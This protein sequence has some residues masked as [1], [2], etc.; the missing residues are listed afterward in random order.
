MVATFCIYSQVQ[1]H[2]FTNFDDAIYCCLDVYA[3]GFTSE[4]IKWA[5]TTFA[6]GNWFPVTWFSHI[7]DYQLYGEQA[8]GYLLTNVFFH[9]ANSLLLF[10]VLFRMTGA[11]WQSAFVASMFA[12]HPLNVESV[13]WAA[14]RKNVLSTLFWLLTMW[15][16]VRYSEKSSAKRYGLVFLF[17]TLGL[18]SKSMLVTLPFVL[19]LLDYWPL[20]RFKFRQERGSNDILEKNTAKGPGALGLVLEKVPLFFLTIGL[21]IVTYIAQKRFGNMN[22]TEHLTFFTR[23]TNAMVSYLEYL[24]KV[25]WPEKLAMFYPHPGNNLPVWK[26]LLCGI[27]L[28]GITIISIRI[29]R[30]APY[31]AVG[32]FWYLGTLLPVIGIVQVGGQAMADRYMYIPL[33]GV[34]IIVA[35]GVPE[36]IS[37]WRYKKNVLSVSAGIIIPALMIVTLGQV[38]QWKNSITVFKHTIRVTDK[39][40]PALAIIHNQLGQALFAEQKNEEAISHYKM[41]IRLNPNFASLAHYNLGILLFTDQNNNEEAIFHYKKAITLTPYFANAHYNLGI[42]LL[43]RGEMK[44]AVHHLRETVRLRPGLVKARDYLKFALIQSQKLE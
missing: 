26:G 14:E 42:I 21:S 3:V 36:L 22:Y 25:I 30:K 10:L 18:M 35:W 11:I 16:Y 19:L 17:F 40:Y 38:S 15:A 12:L 37:K 34:F 44:E 24:R 6:T 31:V 8:K 5:F 28:V 7:L 33:I 29:I 23:I 4:N 9:I 20:R 39:K 2:E 32:W 27:A 1:D 43:Q 13:A 41:A